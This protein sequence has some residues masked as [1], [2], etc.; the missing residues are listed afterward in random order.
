MNTKGLIH[1]GQC[2]LRNSDKQILCK[3]VV[4]CCKLQ[5]INYYVTVMIIYRAQQSEVAF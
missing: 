3:I 5:Q 4:N 2:R 1:Y